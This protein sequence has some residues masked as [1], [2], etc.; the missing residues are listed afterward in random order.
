MSLPSEDF[1]IRFAQPKDARTILGLIREL[2]EYEKMFDEVEATE[3]LLHEAFF[4]RKVAEAI[5]GEINGEAAGY[6]VFFHNFSSFSAQSGIYIEDIYVKPQ[7]RGRGFGKA[8]FAFIAKLALE[9]GCSKLEWTVLDWNEPSKAFYRRIGGEEVSD[10]RVFKL[11][12]K[13]L[14]ALAGKP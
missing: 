8:L 5:I 12:G 11:T 2:A 1:K 10:W 3:Q 6:A 4:E 14:E 9:R 13:K 7:L